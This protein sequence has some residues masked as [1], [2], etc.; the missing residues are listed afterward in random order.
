MSLI[1]EFLWNFIHAKI[2]L[3]KGWYTYDVHENCPIFKPPTTLSIRPKFFHPLDPGRPISNKPPLQMINNQLKENVIQ[4]WL[5]C[6]IRPFL[7]VGFRFQYQ[8]TNLVWLSFDFFLF[9]W[10]PTICFFVALYSC[11]CSCPKSIT[12]CLLLINYSHF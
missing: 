10:S 12:K 7:Q 4:G 5:L 3:L 9:S 1:L 2:Y 6:V 11:V 8:L